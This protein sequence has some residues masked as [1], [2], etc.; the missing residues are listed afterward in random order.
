M[1]DLSGSHYSSI[2][3]C[4]KYFKGCVDGWMSQAQEKSVRWEFAKAVLT[5]EDSW[6]PWLAGGGWGK[7]SLERIGWL[8]YTK[9]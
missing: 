9:L 2:H 7:D 6:A 3:V 8:G 1:V 4:L 5:L